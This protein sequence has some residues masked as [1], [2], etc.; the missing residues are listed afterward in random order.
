MRTGTTEF[1][2]YGFAHRQVFREGDVAVFERSR[3]GGAD[4]QTHYEAVRIKPHEAFV[5]HGNAIPAGESYPSSEKWGQDGFTYQD[6]QL[7]MTRA[8]KMLAS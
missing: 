8:R 5:L 2:K 3:I 1:E 4:A 6:K 7:A